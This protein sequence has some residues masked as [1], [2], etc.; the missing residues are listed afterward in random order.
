MSSP[1]DPLIRIIRKS[2]VARDF[3]G[4]T[5]RHLNT[6]IARGEWEPPDIKATK[7]GEA[8]YYFESTAIKAREEWLRRRGVELASAERRDEIETAKPTPLTATSNQ[9][10]DKKPKR[11]TRATKARSQR[12]AR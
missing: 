1:V 10:S 2:V 3:R 4:C 11:T 7:L 8:D 5:T 12:K 6:L 9:R